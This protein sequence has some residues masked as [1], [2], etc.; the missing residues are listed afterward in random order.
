MRSRLYLSEN[1]YDYHL[2]VVRVQES[3]NYICT[4]PIR[5]QAIVLN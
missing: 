3:R 2:L 1:I 5:R 4:P